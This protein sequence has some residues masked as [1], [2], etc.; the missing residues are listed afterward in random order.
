MSRIKSAK[1]FREW[2][3][4]DKWDWLNRSDDIACGYPQFFD[5]WWDPKRFNWK[6]ASYALA[7]CCYYHFPKWWDP[8]RF[9]WHAG[10]AYLAKYCHDYFLEWWDPERF[11][12]DCGSWTLAQYSHK[13]FH[14]W[15]DPTRYNWHDL[16]EL[17][18]YCRDYF[19][20]WWDCDRIPQEILDRDY[21]W[22]TFLLSTFC[23][24]YADLWMPCL[25]R[26]IPSIRSLVKA[27]L[28]NWGKVARVALTL[29]LEEGSYGKEN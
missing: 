4:P 20:Q 5:I 11:N 12:W 7:R 19:L 3:D 17:V 28:N 27:I 25:A 10:S 16:K 8:T 1:A 23:E 6:H 18:L 14:Q 24:S 21:R 13:Y 9:N 29:T 15:W 2:W 26:R 22:L